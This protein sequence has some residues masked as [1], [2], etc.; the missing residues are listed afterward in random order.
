MSVRDFYAVED[1][2]VGTVDYYAFPSGKWLGRAIYPEA[3]RK[4]LLKRAIAQFE[5]TW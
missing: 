3:V 5:E 1:L 2:T 4:I